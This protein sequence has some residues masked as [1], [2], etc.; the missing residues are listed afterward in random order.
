[1]SE[2]ERLCKSIDQDRKRRRSYQE[3][4]KITK[5]IKLGESVLIYVMALRT[6][7]KTLE[8]DYRLLFPIREIK[9]YREPN[10]LS[11]T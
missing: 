1:M 4:I 9:D 6:Q 10:L 7:V 11:K 5:E 2:S 3:S 8:P